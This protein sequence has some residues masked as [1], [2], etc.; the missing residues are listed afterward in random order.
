MRECKKYRRSKHALLGPYMVLYNILVDD[1]EDIREQGSR[2][3][4]S[5]LSG[6]TDTS[7]SL[8][9][10]VAKSRLLD[11]M[12]QEY[13]GSTMFF[14]EA[15][16]KLTGLPSICSATSHKFVSDKDDRFQSIPLQIRPV[17]ELLLEARTTQIAVFVE[18]KQNLFVD[19]V[20]E[21]DGWANV[22]V[23]MDAGVWKSTVVSDLESWTTN[24]LDYLLRL[25]EK[26]SDHEALSLISIPEVYT[27]FMRVILSAKVLVNGVTQIDWERNEKNYDCRVLLERLLELGTQKRLHGLLMDRIR[28]ILEN[29]SHPTE[30]I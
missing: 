6:H 2:T 26:M 28:Y 18:E 22:L 20:L 16:Q 27:L 30:R 25:C 10:A 4:S 7:L 15:A 14:I 12:E 13:R 8:S 23:N 5:L 24:G 29:K 1:D 3:V 21:A 9:P 19:Q 11:F 17:A